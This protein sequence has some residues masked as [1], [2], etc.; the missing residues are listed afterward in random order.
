M[1]APQLLQAARRQDE[2]GQGDQLEHRRQPGRGQ[3][4]LREGLAGS[5]QLPYWDRI[6]VDEGGAIVTERLELMVAVRPTFH[7]PATL[8]KQAANI[9]RIS[10]GRLALNVV[11]SWWA[12]EAR[13]Y[14]LQ[15]DQHDDV[16]AVLLQRRVHRMPRP[17][18]P[19]AAAAS[20]RLPRAEPLTASVTAEKRAGAGD[21]FHIR[22]LA[23]G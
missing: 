18:P 1:T 9:D 2:R 21:P 4:G 11:S 7:N 15:F 22:P 17:L 12:D 6:I 10:N 3:Q 20:R 14:G 8:A 19:P 13:Q 23:N 5:D 16:G